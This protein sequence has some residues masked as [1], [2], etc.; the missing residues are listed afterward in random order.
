[1]TLTGTKFPSNL[2]W[3]SIGGTRV[4]ILSNTD[5]S[6]VFQSPRMSPGVYSLVIP[7][8]EIGNAKVN[9]QLEYTLF[10]TSFSPRI[11]SIRGN[12]VLTISGQGFSTDCSKNQVSFVDS[13]N[14]NR[15]CIVLSCSSSQIT[16][17]TTNAYST[18]NVANEGTDNSNETSFFINIFVMFILK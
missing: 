9:T 5:T 17:R 4:S 16:C 15:K 2:A 3:L 18:F 10:V 13:L 12:T 8:G 11:G 1:M 14:F 6:I 7:C